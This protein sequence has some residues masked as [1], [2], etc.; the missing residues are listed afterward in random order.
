M[1]HCSVLSY[2]LW[3]GQNPPLPLPPY[4]TATAKKK[5][6]DRKKRE[7][8]KAKRDEEKKRKEEEVNISVVDPPPVCFCANLVTSPLLPTLPRTLI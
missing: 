6:D 1:T 7:E 2:K 3:A 4:L 5:E 8:E